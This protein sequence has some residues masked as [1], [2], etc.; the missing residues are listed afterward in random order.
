MTEFIIN[1]EADKQE[2]LRMIAD[3]ERRTG[4]QTESPDP[5]TAN[6]AETE[7]ADTSRAGR[8]R[9]SSPGLSL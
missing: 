2:A 9:G 7:K 3:Y 1:C 8:N 6:V 5:S 4:R